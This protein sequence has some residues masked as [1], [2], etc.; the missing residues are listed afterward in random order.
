MGISNITK[1]EIF[2]SS[3]ASAVYVEKILKLP[4]DKKV[5]VL[6]EE[7][8]EKELHEL[9]Y[10]TVGGTDP[11]LVKEGVKFDPNTTLFDN[12]DPNVGWLFVD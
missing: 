4:K 10:S 5:W 1:L 7:G 11:K 8:I 6:G 2:G 3:F 12:L 9:G